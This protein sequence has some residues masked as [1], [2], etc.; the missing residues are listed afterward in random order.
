MKSEEQY[1]LE[2]ILGAVKSGGDLE[3]QTNRAGGLLLAFL[4][5]RTM[6]QA[7]VKND[8]IAGRLQVEIGR[9]MPYL[10]NTGGE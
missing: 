3:T 8:P 10:I 9:L 4:R 6:D 5:G 7:N 1:K 2:V